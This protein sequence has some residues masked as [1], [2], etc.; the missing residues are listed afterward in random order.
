[1]NNIDILGYTASFLIVICYLPQIYKIIKTKEAKNISIEMY[2]LLFS[3]QLLYAIYGL[4]KSDIPIITVNLIGG[5]L[6]LFIIM[7]SLY[8]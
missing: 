8:Y 4:L 6:N 1:M 3:G 2:F 5:L 7:L